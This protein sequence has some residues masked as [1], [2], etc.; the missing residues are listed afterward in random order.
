MVTAEPGHQA[1]VGAQ[2]TMEAFDW[3]GQ[4]V[5]NMESLEVTGVQ[6]ALNPWQFDEPRLV[7][8]CLDVPQDDGFRLSLIAI[9]ATATSRNVQYSTSPLLKP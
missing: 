4:P 2:L 1:P 5:G 7:R 3:N 8:M 6:H 9:A